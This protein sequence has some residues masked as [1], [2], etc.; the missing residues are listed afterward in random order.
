MTWI[1]R[2][3]CD[4]IAAVCHDLVGI[5]HNF[6]LLVAIVPMQPHAFANDFKDIQDLEWPIALMRAQFAMIGMINGN[7]RVDTRFAGRLEFPKLQLALER[8][9]YSDID[10]LQ[11]HRRLFQVDKFNA[12]DDP[13]NF[14]GGFDDACHAG[15]FVQRD[16]HF[17]PALQ[18][19][20]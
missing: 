11:A 6:K 2:V 18:V 10:A 1:K 4:Q 16:P 14:N 5:L 12:G 9:K 13:Q 20:L 8:G 7:Q 19:R 3:L 15:M 17:D